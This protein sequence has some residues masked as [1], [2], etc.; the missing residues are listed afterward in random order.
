MNTSLLLSIL[1]ISSS[2]PGTWNLKLETLY[3][4]SLEQGST[5]CLIQESANYSPPDT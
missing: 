4:T 1:I 3:N 2:F 5:N